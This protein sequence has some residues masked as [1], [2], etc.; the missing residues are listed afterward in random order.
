MKNYYKCEGCGVVFS[1][2][3]TCRRHEAAC[4]GNHVLIGIEADFECPGN[5]PRVERRPLRDNDPFLNLLKIRGWILDDDDAQT[6]N[7]VRLKYLEGALTE[8]EAREKL[9]TAITGLLDARAAE[10]A[11]FRR[12]VEKMFGT[13]EANT[14]QQGE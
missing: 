11:D 7:I 5:G 9:R 12:N 13:A 6:D 8:A 3:E 1:D 4:C 2:A 14:A 10:L